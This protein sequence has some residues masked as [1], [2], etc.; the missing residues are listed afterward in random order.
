MDTTGNKKDTRLFDKL[1]CG[2]S[3]TDR[4][5]VVFMSKGEI[6]PD[7]I[8]LSSSFGPLL[9]QFPMLPEQA[10]HLAK[11]LTDMADAIQA[12]QAA[13]CAPDA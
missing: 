12:I 6:R 4:L 1:V 3:A 8:F 5:D 13:E 11:C 9:F 7:R 2:M 10:R